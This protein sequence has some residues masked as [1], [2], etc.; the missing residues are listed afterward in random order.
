MNMWRLTTMNL[1]ELLR[2]LRAG[3]SRNAIARAMHV[4]PNTVKDY[5][6]WAEAQQLLSGPLPDLTTL[7]ALRAQTFRADRAPRHPNVSSLEGY[8]AEVTE[9]LS[10]GRQ[11]LSIWRIL[12]GRY[13][14]VFSASPS[15]V[16]RL[17]RSVRASQPPEVTVRIETAPGEVAQVDFG[18]LGVLRD[19]LTGE[20]RKGWVFVM[21]LAWSRHMYAEI[22]F[23][24]SVFTWL[25]C[26]QHAFEFFGAVP[27]RIVLDNLKAAVIRAYTRD[28]DPE[29][30]QSYRECAEHYGFLIDPCLPRKPQHKGKVERGGVGYIQQAFVPLLPEGVRRSEANRLLRPWLLTEAGLRVHGTTRERPLTRFEQTERAALLP[31]PT[32]AYDPAVWKRCMLQR[33]GHVTFEKAYYSAPYRL[34]GQRLW[35]RAGLREIRLFSEDFQLVTTHPRARQPGQRFTQPDHLPAHLAQAL[36]LTRHACYAQAEAIGPATHQVV[37][38][39]LASRPV[40]R[41]RT[42]LRVLRLADQFTPARLEA[43]CARGLAHG[44]TSFRTLK[45]ILH[46]GLDASL[47]LPLPTPSATEPLV[48]ARRP[49]E[50]AE[51]IWTGAAWN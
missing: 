23:D 46:E 25:V 9:L 16:D 7:E 35:V 51:A 3:E 50:W 47:P 10:Q 2:R 22:V 36:T 15:A 49:E 39:L 13:P 28:E 21:T 30:Q 27:K 43:A 11:P 31:L 48:F 8:R 38:D 42:A 4:S 14:A 44:D 33:D 32:T 5:R 24:Q 45:C 18:Y 20:L 41:F 29:I 40:D 34:I 26:H 19:D 17:V 6:R 37:T 12:K 1:H